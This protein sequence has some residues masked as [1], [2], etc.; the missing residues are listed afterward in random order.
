MSRARAL[1]LIRRI[2]EGF[3]RH[4]YFFII[5]AS[6][7]IIPPVEPYAHQVEP[8]FRVSF[9]RPLRILVGTR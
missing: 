4:P 3:E 7:K 9:R 5:R 8:L 6:E 1:A 2:L